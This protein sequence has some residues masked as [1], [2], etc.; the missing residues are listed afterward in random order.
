MQL[1]QLYINATIE[2]QDLQLKHNV[3]GLW[4]VYK[5]YLNGSSCDG[6]HAIRHYVWIGKKILERNCRDIRVEPKLPMEHEMSNKPPT[7]LPPLRTFVKK[8]HFVN[9]L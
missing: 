5:P 3:L 9:H 2:I 1:L 4:Y 7:L 6:C 8:K